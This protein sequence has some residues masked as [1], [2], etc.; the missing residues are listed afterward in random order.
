MVE[1]GETTTREGA[2]DVA[3]EVVGNLPWELEEE[4]GAGGRKR[5]TEVRGGR[6]VDGTA[7]WR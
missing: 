2:E 7:R 4:G 1:V 6:E 3:A 5:M